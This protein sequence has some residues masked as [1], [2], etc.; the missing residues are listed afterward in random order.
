M[1][2][3][4]IQVDPPD[5]RVLELAIE[6]LGGT[7]LITHNMSE[8][9]RK[10]MRDKH[11]LKGKQPRG[12]RDIDAEYEAA[13]YRFADG[14][15]GLPCAAFKK[16]AVRAA[17][18]V[19]GMTMTDTRM[20]FFVLADDRCTTG[21]DCVRI[22]SEEVE[23]REDTVTVQGSKDL[24][25][26]PEFRNWSATLKISYNA[27]IISPEIIANLFQLAGFSVGVGEWRPEKDGDAGRFTVKAQVAVELSE[28]A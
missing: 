19:N 3:T 7:G 26:R 6:G 20:S 14:T 18:G 24:R 1:T 28:A 17:K 25:Y 8:K 27:G 2:I 5:I 9:A 15:S 23:L 16:A 10:Q 21:M 13:H 22:N 12:V 4:Q 11:A